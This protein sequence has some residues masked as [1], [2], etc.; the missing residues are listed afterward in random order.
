MRGNGRSQGSSGRRRRPSAV[1]MHR[2]DETDVTDCDDHVQPV[3]R[4]LTLIMP[5]TSPEDAAAL[6]ALFGHLQSQP[7]EVNPVRVALGKIG[8]VH[9]ARFTFLD[10]DSKLAVI[11]SYD[12]RFDTYIN[13]FVN[14]IGDVFDKI[15]AHVADAPPL[16]VTVHRQEFLRYV[17]DHDVPS[18]DFYSAYPDLTV[19]DILALAD[20]VQ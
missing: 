7:P 4:P 5:I 13:E 10:D 18:V 14:E 6:R 1:S 11:T 20:Q 16:P 9:F 8:T 3:Q 12:G 19:L 17:A 15:L 2:E